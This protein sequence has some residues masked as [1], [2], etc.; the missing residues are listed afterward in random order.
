[1]EICLI[2]TFLGFVSNG[3][4]WLV[5]KFDHNFK[6]LLR[7]IF[8]K[9]LWLPPKKFEYTPKFRIFLNNNHESFSET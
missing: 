6:K 8:K 1:M 3:T 2:K 9:E 4:F 7:M 5:R